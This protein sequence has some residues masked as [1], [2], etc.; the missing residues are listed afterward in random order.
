[1]P[2]PTATASA[3]AAA[4]EPAVEPTVKRRLIAMVYEAFLLL[5]VEMSAVAVYLLATGNR[6]G[7]V[8]EHG[9]KAFLFLVTGAY[10]I[11]SWTDGGH[12]LAMKTWRLR[13]V[14]DGHA[15]M[16]LRTAALRYLLAWG[17]FLPALLACGVLGLRDRR[18][19]G[20]ALAAG[21]AAWACTAFLDRDRRFLHD[22]LAGTRIVGLP[23]RQRPARPGKARP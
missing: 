15:R 17:W 11:R 9:L 14:A 22:R 5:A 1:M 4:A 19:I 2:E 21:I 20:I 13:V 7:P 18:D 6:H 16:P 12:T 23:K 3:P 8:F 10:F